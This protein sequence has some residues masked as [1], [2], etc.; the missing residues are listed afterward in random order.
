MRTRLYDV[1]LYMYLNM[2][3]GDRGKRSWEP[4]ARTRKMSHDKSHQSR[5]CVCA[6]VCVRVCTIFLSLLYRSST[7][8]GSQRFSYPTFAAVV[9]SY[10]P[11]VCCACSVCNIILY[12][13]YIRHG[14]DTSMVQCSIHHPI[15]LFYGGGRDQIF[16][17]TF[18]I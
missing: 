5:V 11:D 3:F 16:Y 2:Y 10:A 15:L 14:Y 6:C 8:Y 4:F 12:Y 7:L 9:E 1:I 13:V 17:H 18:S